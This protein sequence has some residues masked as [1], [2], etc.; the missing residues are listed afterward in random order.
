M[1]QSP[2]PGL[3]EGLRSL[4]D[5]NFLG[6]V[7]HQEQQSRAV[8]D[9]AHPKIITFEKVFQA[10]MAKLGVPMFCHCMVR[11]RAAQREAFV[12]GYS[13]NNG[14]TDFPHLAWAVDMNHSLKAWDVPKS[15]WTMIGH[16]GKE[17]AA[18]NGIK[19]VWGGEFKSL[20]DPAH[21]ELAGWKDMAGELPYQTVNIVPPK[22][23]RA[24][25]VPK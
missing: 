10:R 15:A 24:V 16:I 19:I 25:P 5:R 20:Y 13:R 4:V 1:S 18:Q 23:P 17:V 14:V 12:K 11:T 3:S 22:L 8:R 21:W 6:S 9:G 7:R 2:E